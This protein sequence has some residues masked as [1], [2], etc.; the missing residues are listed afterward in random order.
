MI[1]KI[2]SVPDLVKKEVL[3][4]IIALAALALLSATFDAPVGGP[5]DASGAPEE[6]VKAPWIF[7]GIQQLLRYLPG[8]IAGVALPLAALA[9]MAAIPFLPRER[10]LVTSLIF[11]AIA[12]ALIGFTA[13]GYIV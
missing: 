3:A 2:R 9:L 13:W 7:V 5:S 1:R 11:F 6:H 8:G 4:A 10:K 12:L